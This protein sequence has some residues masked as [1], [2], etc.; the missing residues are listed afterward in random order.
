MSHTIRTASVLSMRA[1]TFVFMMIVMVCTTVG[2]LAGFHIVLQAKNLV[3]M[4][5]GQYGSRQHHHA[6]YH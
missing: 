6:D 1:M 5:M 4:M 2:T 3:M